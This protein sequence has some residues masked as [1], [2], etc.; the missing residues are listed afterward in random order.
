MQLRR[1]AQF[2]EMNREGFRKIVKKHDKVTEVQLGHEVMPV[3]QSLLPA[4]DVDAV[5]KACT[6]FWFGKATLL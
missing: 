6:P 1:F 2:I 4:D 3:V 5:Q